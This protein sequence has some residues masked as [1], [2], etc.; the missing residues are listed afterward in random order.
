MHKKYNPT[1]LNIYEVGLISGLQLGLSI[2]KIA[3]E[4]E[5]SQR[6]VCF[7]IQ[8]LLIRYGCKDVNSLLQVLQE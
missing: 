7:M 2:T 3:A 8:K 4:L 6:S 5:V 1:S